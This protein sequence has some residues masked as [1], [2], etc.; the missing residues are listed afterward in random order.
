MMIVGTDKNEEKPAK[1]AKPEV[2]LSFAESLP[3]WRLFNRFKQIPK[4]YLRMLCVLYWVLTFGILG[5]HMRAAVNDKNYTIDWLTSALLTEFV[6][7]TVVFWGA[8]RIC[9]WIKDDDVKKNQ[10]NRLYRMHKGVW[11]LLF[12]V[13]VMLSITTLLFVVKEMIKEKPGFWMLIP[14]LFVFLAVT[15]IYC[16][17]VRTSLWIY[18]G[19]SDEK[20]KDG[21]LK[22]K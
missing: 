19:F 3:D 1:P 22:P 5:F 2:K 7:F 16:F 21:N 4:N 18:D 15:A 20:K 8:L 9:L 10:T 12:C 6:V 13:Y 11:R 17:A 14:L